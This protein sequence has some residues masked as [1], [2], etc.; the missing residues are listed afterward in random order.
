MQPLRTLSGHQVSWQLK[1]DMDFLSQ[2]NDE[3]RRAVDMTQGPLI[4][5]AGPGT[6]KTKTLAHKFAY[7]LGELGVD[8]RDI[9]A[10]TFTKKAAKEL[11][12]RVAALLPAVR[13]DLNIG[14]FHALAFQ[15]LTGVGVR[16][17]MASAEYQHTIL[18]ELMAER[19]LPHHGQALTAPEVVRLFS[20]VKNGVRVDS[21]LTPEWQEL[22]TAY[23]A[24]LRS[25][26]YFD[27]DDLLIEA[28]V[29]MRTNAPAYLYVLLDEFQ[30]TNELQYQLLRLMSQKA[31]QVCVIG[32]PYQ[33]IYSFRGASDEIF[34]RFKND[35]GGVHEIVLRVNYRS[36][37]MILRASQQL[38]PQAA[39]L[40]AT[41]SG[42]GVVTCVETINDATEAAW[43]VDAVRERVGGTDL[44]SVD[45]RGAVDAS[46]TFA[47]FAVVY[48]VHDIGR[49]VARAF[50]RSGIPY[51]VVG[52]DSFYEQPL[53]ITL[54][55]C[56]QLIAANRHGVPHV[57]PDPGYD[58]LMV[59]RMKRLGL[60]V[61]VVLS[62][63]GILTISELVQAIFDRM[64]VS[65]SRKKYFILLV[66]ELQS[67]LARYDEHPDGLTSF[68][69]YVHYLD[70][71]DYYDD[72][73]DAVT[74]LT[75]HA[76][77]G[78]EFPYVFI[79]GFEEGIIPHENYVRSPAAL[80][81]EKRLLYVAMTRA[82]LELYLLFAHSRRQQK[83]RISQFRAEL[84]SVDDIEDERIERWRQQQAKVRAQ[85][86]Q[87]RLW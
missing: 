50:Q 8:S 26:N 73:R 9:V 63:A 56:L 22:L 7:L 85:K 42:E 10:V 19:E 84:F 5:V 65:E 29:Q 33:S 49:G 39:K 70:T 16:V 52:G 59:R 83:A 76:A 12:E 69:A 43:I 41:R 35:Y 31:R 82:Q 67:H 71:H 68:L 17:R 27:Y 28:S 66:Q 47:D 20:C 74:L 6:G 79:C 78:L 25:D 87:L 57:P 32:D 80:E 61:E 21:P 13:A 75:M 3:Q 15:W 38:F 55:Y 34:A 11:H 86:S 51:Q 54:I 4:I 48:R 23:T 18:Q 14:T 24:R 30:D 60:S 36:R 46:A 37:A 81:E 40:Q 58:A 1:Y 53:V 77:K 44:G 62:L 2:L 45:S 72:R 64:K